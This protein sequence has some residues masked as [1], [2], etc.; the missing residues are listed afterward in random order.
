[1][2]PSNAMKDVLI[3]TMWG[4]SGGA[5]VGGALVVHDMLTGRFS[6]MHTSGLEACLLVV[7]ITLRCLPHLRQP[8]P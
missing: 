5:L 8:K 2:A 4:A 3:G 1:M 7:G 6:W